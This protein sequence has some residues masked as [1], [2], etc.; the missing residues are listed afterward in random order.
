MP[1]IINRFLSTSNR[2]EKTWLNEV[3]I[4]MQTINNIQ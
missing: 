1:K 3:Q 2:A 4:Y